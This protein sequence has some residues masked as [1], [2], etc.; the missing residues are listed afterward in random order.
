MISKELKE[1]IVHELTLIT[2]E[3]GSVRAHEKMTDLFVDNPRQLRNELERLMI[4][5]R[6]TLR[7]QN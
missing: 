7:N 5:V 4:E 6:R 2:R 1:K 3:H